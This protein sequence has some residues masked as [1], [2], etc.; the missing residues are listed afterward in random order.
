ME[1]E[2]FNNSVNYTPIISWALVVTIAIVIVE[3]WIFLDTTDTTDRAVGLAIGAVMWVIGFYGTSL[4]I[5][6]SRRPKSVEVSDHGVKLNMRLGKRPVV[7][8]WPDVRIIGFQTSIT[9]REEGLICNDVAWYY[10]IDH[11]IAVEL[12]EAYHQRMGGYPPKTLDELCPGMQKDIMAMSSSEWN[13][14]Y[15]RFKKKD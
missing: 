15:E 10:P 3:V 2:K 1:T 6:Y 8:A 4:K 9:G 7:I 12:R 14:K 13:R 5:F 11:H